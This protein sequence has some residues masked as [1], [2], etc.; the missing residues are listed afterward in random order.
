MINEAPEMSA[1][2]AMIPDED[3][4][5]ELPAG[6]VLTLEEEKPLASYPVVAFSISY[7]MDLVGI[8]QL[9]GKAGIPHFGTERTDEDPFVLVGGPMTLSNVLP[10]QPFADAVVMGDAEAVLPA[11]LEILR[12]ADSHA[13][14]RERLAEV[15]GVYVPEHHGWDVPDPNVAG[16]EYLPAYGTFW[17]PQSELTNM[18]LVESSR[19]C[20]QYCK[21]CVV[22]SA[23]TP[24]RYPDAKEILQTI[25]SEAPRVGFVGAAVSE[26][27]QIKELLTACVDRDQE[28]GL[29]SLRADV[30]DDEFVELLVRGGARTMTIASDAPSELQRSRLAKGLKERHLI[31]AAELARKHGLH[32]LKVYSI[33]GLPGETDE[34]LDELARFALEMSRIHKVTLAVNPLVPKLRTPLATA[35]FCPIPDLNRKIKRLRKKAGGRVDFRFLS[36]RWA[37]VEAMLSLGGPETGLAAVE[38]A[39]AGGGFHAWKAALKQLEQPFAARSFAEETGRSSWLPRR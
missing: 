39:E 15:Q 35:S 30:L 20:P 17:S 3:M 7:E 28:I 29:S 4:A 5:D 9:L 12:S 2:R 11:I 38:V 24:M 25:P 31:H 6:G 13:E 10:L 36:P 16:P 32:R 18:F 19:G 33:I 8:I 27:P 21:F 34:D 37:W 26:Y 23:N 22:R 14:R 1:S